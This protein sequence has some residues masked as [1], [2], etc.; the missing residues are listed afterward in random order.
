MYALNS[1]D[2]KYFEA[3][4]QAITTN[5][6][7]IWVGLARVTIQLMSQ[8]LHCHSH[9]RGACALNVSLVDQCLKTSKSSLIRTSTEFQ[10]PL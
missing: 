3:R 1:T 10:I 9:S 7:L 5:S 4:L 2:Q 6:L 8:H